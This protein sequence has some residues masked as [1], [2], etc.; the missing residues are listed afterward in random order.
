LPLV[1]FNTEKSES[2]DGFTGNTVASPPTISQLFIQTFP[3]RSMMGLT[4]STLVTRLFGAKENCNL[5]LGLDAAGKMT[6]LYKLKL[7]EMVPPAPSPRLE[8]TLK[9]WLSSVAFIPSPY[10]VAVHSDSSTEL[11]PSTSSVLITVLVSNT[12][13]IDEKKAFAASAAAGNEHC[14]N[15]RLVI[16]VPSI[17]AFAVAWQ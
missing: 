11:Y 13:K 6:I 1:I 8:A 9:R 14:L 12:D 3:T 10:C 15:S 4:I 2:T 16:A 17:Y 7:G 5:I